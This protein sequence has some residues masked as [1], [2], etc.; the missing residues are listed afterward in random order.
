MASGEE[1]ANA[2]HSHSDT[3]PSVSQQRG[4]RP[5]TNSRLDL[6]HFPPEDGV[7][8]SPYS[9][10]PSTVWKK[11]LTGENTLNEEPLVKNS[12]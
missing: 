8:V 3:P 5:A 4:R 12:L 6:W 11:W 2:G 7:K 10:Y 1:E 9:E